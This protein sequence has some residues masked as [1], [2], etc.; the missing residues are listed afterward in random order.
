LQGRGKAGRPD[1]FSYAENNGF[2]ATIRIWEFRKIGDQDL[3]IS[4]S[5]SSLLLRGFLTRS[6]RGRLLSQFQDMD[7]KLGDFIVA[8]GHGHPLVMMIV[9]FHTFFLIVLLKR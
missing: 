2:L 5:S 9:T 8:E 7:G 3:G 1:I 6:F 4:I